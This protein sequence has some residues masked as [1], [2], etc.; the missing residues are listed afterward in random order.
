M[1]TIFVSSTIRDLGSERSALK[2]FLEN[3]SRSEKLKVLLSEAPDFPYGPDDTLKSVYEICIQNVQASDF[4][5]LLLYQYYG[6][7][8]QPSNDRFVSITHREY[9][10]AM[11][12]HIPVFVLAHSSLWQKYQSS[13]S[14]RSPSDLSEEDAL[15][16]SFL[17]E[18]EN[19]A[20]KK[21]IH[22]FQ[23]IDE[24][25]AIVQ[26]TLLSY[27][28]SDLIADVTY[29]DGDKVSVGERFNKIWRI[30]NTGMQ[31]WRNRLLR[32]EN[33]GNGLT[34]EQQSI[35]V[36]P[37]LPTQ[38]VDLSVWFVAPKYSGTYISYWKMFE[39]DG[40]LCFPW[41]KGIWC[42]VNVVY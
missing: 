34:P 9:L 17:E 23:N 26:S 39:E 36:P 15:L 1:R 5:I 7:R 25:K 33:P 14:I 37:T 27:D 38:E 11:R 32:E 10:E 29:P 3:S 41:K 40:R 20:Q 2:S 22:Q 12:R 21:W 42:K 30:K 16:I 28:G 31:T 19:A 18:I 4:F 8:N 35:P 24:L 6:F 13:R